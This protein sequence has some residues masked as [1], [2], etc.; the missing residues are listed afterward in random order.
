MPPK[1]LQRE[2]LEDM[3]LL[4]V[5]SVNT[6]SSLG[7]MVYHPWVVRLNE[8]TNK[9]IQLT[10]RPPRMSYYHLP[11]K[12]TPASVSVIDTCLPLTH[13]PPTLTLTLRPAIQRH[14]G[15]RHI[16]SHYHLSLND[17]PASDN[18]T[19]PPAIQRHTGLRQCHGVMVYHID[20][21][22]P[23]THRSSTFKIIPSTYHLPPRDT[24]ALDIYIYLYTFI[25][26]FK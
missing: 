10:H 18:V 11:S 9:H 15:P 19:L 8:Q 24:P 4:D 23:L 6:T 12:D 21:C 3:A 2:R 5:W 13:R 14:T 1:D 22:L 16:P 20:T 17:T 26:T 25:Y 7:S